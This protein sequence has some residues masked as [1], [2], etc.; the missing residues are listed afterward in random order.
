[1]C[2]ALRAWAEP[3]LYH[4]ITA[5]WLKRLADRSQPP[6]A[7]LE[8]TLGARPGLS[9]LVRSI[10]LGRSATGLELR[11]IE[12]CANVTELVVPDLAFVLRTSSQHNVR[13]LRITSP[14]WM[15]N[16][17]PAF[18]FPSLEDL[19]FLVNPSHETDLGFCNPGDSIGGRL[20]CLSIGGID[21]RTTFCELLQLFA[22]VDTVVLTD[23]FS[24]KRY[25]R[26]HRMTSVIREQNER[27]RIRVLVLCSHSKFEEAWLPRRLDR[28]SVLRGLTPLR[29]V[30]FVTKTP[31]MWNDI[32][33]SALLEL[34][35]ALTLFALWYPECCEKEVIPKLSD[36]LVKLLQGPSRTSPLGRRLCRIRSCFSASCEERGMLDK[37]VAACAAA[38]IDYAN[39]V[40]PGRQFKWCPMAGD[41]NLRTLDVDWPMPGIKIFCTLCAR[42]THCPRL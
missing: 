32:P 26:P 5:D 15:Y 39:Q 12:G 7:L 23:F 10:N 40:A 18:R 27:I 20:Q 24:T 33:P 30:H 19:R 3:R 21:F 34:P 22:K 2:K 37:L 9:A 35:P 31:S 36:S 6:I 14:T 41:I 11:V 16:L 8:R 38:G 28:N 25:K 29:H 42:C 13:H 4:T 17:V 1:M